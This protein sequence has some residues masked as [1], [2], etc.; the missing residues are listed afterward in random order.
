MELYR[1]KMKRT[2]DWFVGAVVCINDKAYG[3]VSE[4]LFPERPAYSRMAIGYGL[5][6]KGITND[7]AKGAEFG[8]EQALQRYE[9]GFPQWEEL[10]PETV[11]RCTGKHDIAGN[12]LFEGDVIKN[13]E[14]LVMEICYGEYEAFCPADRLFENNIGFFVISKDVEECLGVCEP[15]PLGPTEDY[16]CLIGNIFD[17]P[18]LKQTEERVAEFG[19]Q[20]TLMPAT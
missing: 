10:E 19:D 17:T 5:R 16:A 9:A 15:M 2:G 13:P 8:W 4:R 14:N 11:T 3:L 7:G 20:D 6:D 1:G 18:M 12:V